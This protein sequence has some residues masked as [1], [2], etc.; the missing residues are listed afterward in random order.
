V[1]G[2][3]K[4]RRERVAADGTFTRGQVLALKKHRLQDHVNTYTWDVTVGFT[5][6]EGN[7][8]E[9][10]QPVEFLAWQGPPEIGD[11]VALRYDPA[12]PEYW[13]WESL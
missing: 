1:F 10:T 3:K 4:K 12:E 6:D 9:A 2:G 8:V 13:V 5:T 11:P 7:P